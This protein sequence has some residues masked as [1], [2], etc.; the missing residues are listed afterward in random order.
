MR[1]MLAGSVICLSSGGCASTSSANT[2]II[3]T[4]DTRI[5]NLHKVS[6]GIY[7]SG[8]LTAEN[9][10]T[11]ADEYG[12]KTIISVD[13]YTLDED[14]KEAEMKAAKLNDLTWKWLPIHPIGDLNTKKVF[15]V[16]KALEDAERPVLLHCRRG[17]ERTGIVFATYRITHEGWSFN[18]AFAEMDS[19]G[20]SHLYNE[21]KIDLR[22]ALTK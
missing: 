22:S 19:Y 2:T 16:V 13:S 15:S 3:P 21:W 14:A 11:L 6:D 1:Y 20:F 10:K 4:I 7:R 18:D 17:S 8:T 12:I 5:V 9:V